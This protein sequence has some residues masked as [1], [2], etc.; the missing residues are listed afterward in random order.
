[1]KYYE[2]NYEEYLETIKKYNIHPELEF[3]QSKKLSDIGNMIFYGPSGVGKYTQVLYFLSK[4]SNLKHDKK[5]TIQTDKLDYTYHIS[6]IHYEI[7]MSLLGVNS[8]IIWHEIFLQIVD[9]IYVKTEKIG[10]IVCKNFH[11][12]HS[13]LLEIFYSYI[14]QYS[15]PS[16][17]IQI[18]F[19]LITEH[20]SFIPNN[21]IQSCKVFNIRRPEK[22]DR[23]V[24]NKKINFHPTTVVPEL[25][26]NEKFIRRVYSNEYDKPNIVSFLEK[27]DNSSITNMKEIYSFDLFENDE[28]NVP[29]DI[30]NIVCDNII[31]EISKPKKLS[32]VNFRDTIYDIL[33]YNLD[34][35]ECIWFILFHFIHEKF[36]SQES[37][38][39]ILHKTYSFLKYYN[40][41]YRPIYHLESIFFTIITNISRNEL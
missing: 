32:F 8:K 37:A 9:I 41:N 36:I 11:M 28:E 14:Q 40:N 12:I 30:F 39:I 38:S 22:Y 3:K 13:E 26:K 27:V 10:V 31:K 33:I 15:H 1:M 24:K 35:G 16:S 21:I 20:L 2:T 17:S 4:Y 29:T 18:F 23:I 25:S 7:D 5:I 19:V 34:V 6:D